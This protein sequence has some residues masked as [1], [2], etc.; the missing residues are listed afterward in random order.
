MPRAAQKV[1]PQGPPRRSSRLATLPGSSGQ[2]SAAVTEPSAQPPP[3]T[4]KKT[5]KSRSR[6]RKKA[7]LPENTTESPA[8]GIAVA[9][10]PVAPVAPP[11]PA[12][13]EQSLSQPAAMESVDNE[14]ESTTP[15]IVQEESHRT[16]PAAATLPL[17]V[18]QAR[19]ELPKKAADPDLQGAYC[20]ILRSFIVLTSVLEYI[21][22]D[23][24]DEHEE[25]A[26]S[27]NEP[28]P[29]K[30]KRG[31]G[32]PPKPKPAAPIA[33]KV[34][35]HLEPL[36]LPDE[37]PMRPQAVFR[38]DFGG[39]SKTVKIGLWDDWDGTR[40]KFLDAMNIAPRDRASVRLGF[41]CQDARVNDPPTALEDSDEFDDLMK[42]LRININDCA[43]SKVKSK[44]PVMIFN[45]SVSLGCP[46]IELASDSFPLGWI[47]G[48]CF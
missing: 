7:A 32:R 8:E 21:I 1:P 11:Q 36:P 6:S 42:E 39:A 29:E 27:V 20:G 15:V 41:K 34:A 35:T 2:T 5:T 40:I 10:S 38:C 3:T 22:D 19:A 26:L 14:M 24:E 28:S 16:A 45:I 33:K 18:K 13:P 17:P 9:A 43:R 4:T 46:Y 37:S 12:A 48:A 30:P 31:R 47:Y 44:M 23:D 25:W